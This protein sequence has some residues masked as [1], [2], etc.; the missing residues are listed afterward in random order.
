ML[1]GKAH[2]YTPTCLSCPPLSGN[3]GVVWQ[4]MRTAA[5]CQPYHGAH[6]LCA[7]WP[8]T[9]HRSRKLQTSGQV[10]ADPSW[11]I[12]RRCHNMTTWHPPN[13][14]VLKRFLGRPKGHN[15][16]DRLEVFSQK[17]LFTMDTGPKPGE[18]WTQ[19]PKIRWLHK[20]QAHLHLP[21]KEPRGVCL[22]GCTRGIPPIL[23]LMNLFLDL[24]LNNFMVPHEFLQPARNRLEIPSRMGWTR[25]DMARSCSSI[26]GI[27]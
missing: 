21:P 23:G 19:R 15:L 27:R 11:G 10:P 16:C 8:D 7:P 20:K 14:G 9:L 13:S 18:K 22:T 25:H 2:L 1:T 5:L 3:K 12:K 24:V 6:A 4:A 17:L 26:S